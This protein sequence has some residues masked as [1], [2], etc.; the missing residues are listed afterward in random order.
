MGHLMWAIC[1]VLLSFCRDL[2]AQCSLE[3]TYGIED[4]ET[5]KCMCSTLDSHNTG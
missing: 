4:A 3:S 2:R 5:V 1:I